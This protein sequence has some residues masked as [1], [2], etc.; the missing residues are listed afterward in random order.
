MFP[1]W[2]SYMRWIRSIIVDF[3]WPE[4]PTSATVCEGLI[5]RSKP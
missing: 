4:V 3:P 5:L 2:S 1:E